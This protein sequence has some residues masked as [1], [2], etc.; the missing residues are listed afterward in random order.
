MKNSEYYIN[1][2]FSEIKS[3]EEAKKLKIEVDNWIK[4]ADDKEIAS[5]LDSG[6][7]EMLCMICLGQ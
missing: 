7:G 5:Y 4:S 6:A 1:R 2:V 3:I